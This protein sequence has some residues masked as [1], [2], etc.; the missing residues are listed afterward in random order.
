MSRDSKHLLLALLS[1]PVLG[2]P[3]QPD[4]C[5][6][7]SLANTNQ[8]LIIPQ[9]AAV[10]STEDEGMEYA[11]WP[12]LP[13]A[14]LHL[15]LH[16]LPPMPSSLVY[17][18]SLSTTFLWCLFPIPPASSSIPRQVFSPFP[19]FC[20]SHFPLYLPS[21][22][23]SSFTLHRHRNRARIFALGRDKLSDAR[24]YVNIILPGAFISLIP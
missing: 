2:A 12:L 18:L 19:F 13:P 10:N 5:V 21:C 6:Q 11:M 20:S 8:N 7:A 24:Y 15:Y 22:L 1:L 14:H 23:P 3:T 16:D 4:F 9:V 17:L